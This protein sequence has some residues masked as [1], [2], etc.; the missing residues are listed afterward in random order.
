ML[1]KFPSGQCSSNAPC[2]FPSLPRRTVTIRHAAFRL[3]NSFT[4]S[5][6]CPTG[7][8][9]SSRITPPCWLTEIVRVENLNGALLSLTPVTSIWMLTTARAVLR[10]SIL[11]QCIIAI[12]H[13]SGRRS[14]SCLDFPP[15]RETRS[16]HH[17][18]EPLPNLPEYYRFPS[19]ARIACRYHFHGPFLVLSYQHLSTCFVLRPNSPLVQFLCLA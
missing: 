15:L 16:Q 11:R 8:G 10:R 17:R 3:L 12:C 4:S 7:S 13:S 2:S 9:A 19:P 6:L 14:D 1:Q 18:H 5:N